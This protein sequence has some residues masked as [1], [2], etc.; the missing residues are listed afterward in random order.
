MRR[1]FVLLLFAISA[2]AALAEI[3][4]S[5]ITPA[6]GLVSGGEI[7]H[8]HGTNLGEPPVACAPLYCGLTVT[9]GGTRA[10]IIWDAAG[11]IIAI[12]PPHAAG[13]VD[14]VVQVAGSLPVTVAN[15]FSYQDP[16]SDVVKLLLP[17][18]ASAA[19]AFNTSWQTDVL[20]HNESNESLDVA[21]T[22]VPA[23]STKR[24][25][26]AP[27]STGMFIEL[28]RRVFE[29]ITVTT[30]V[31]D[32][33]HDAD[34]LGV[35][36]PSVPETQFRRSIDLSGIPNDTRYRVLLRVYGYGSNSAVNV[37]T[38]DDTTGGLLEEKTV[39]MVGSAPAYVQLP[40]GAGPA[41]G[42]VRIGVTTANANDP[43]IWGFITLTNNVTESVTTITPSTGIA[44]TTPAQTL[45][46]GHWGHAGYCMTVQSQS[47]DL[48]YSCSAGTFPPPVVDAAGHFEADGL[49][50]SV[51]GPLPPFPPPSPAAH[52]S[53]V[54]RGTNL[55]LTI[56]LESGGTVGPLT[57][58]FGSTDPCAVGGCP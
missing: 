15:G 41:T 20:A 40:V 27:P 32:L 55:T 21:G 39:T 16:K 42:R 53:G 43:P 34:T 7:V 30:H 45:T 56:R 46:Q 4:I 1:A 14:V 10:T 58:Q 11:E 28:P 50:S 31:H 19:G 48:H 51:S 54:L 29:N 24:L 3:T 36:I 23:F 8:I 6:A 18:A 52:Y 13:A 38:Y 33:I 5:T 9:F 17:V 37:W 26:L 22:T 47:V 35:D 44:P 49:F 57:L 2:P 12:A 25:A